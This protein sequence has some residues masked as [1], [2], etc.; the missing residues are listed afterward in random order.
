MVCNGYTLITY[1]RTVVAVSLLCLILI[2][3][4]LSRLGKIRRWFL[5]SV[6]S[7][8]FRIPVVASEQCRLFHTNR[9][10]VMNRR[11]LDCEGSREPL[12]QCG[13]LVLRR[14][15]FPC[16]HF[17]QNK[18]LRYEVSQIHTTRRYKISRSC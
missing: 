10:V 4:F 5:L 1:R 11:R 2:P 13:H 18:T 17:L 8:A 15:G 12:L 3:G 14:Q 16:F 9:H 7:T 6:D